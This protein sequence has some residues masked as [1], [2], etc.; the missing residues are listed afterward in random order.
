[1]IGI[2]LEL[3]KQFLLKNEVVAIPTETVYGLAANAL[4]PEAVLKIFEV[5]NRPA[6]DPL[7]VHTD[8]IDK[9][10]TFV[11]E[12][13]E[14]AIQLFKHFSPGALTILLPKKDIIPDITTSGLEKVG[15]RIPNHPLT[16]QLLTQLD[17]PL[18]APSA[19]PFGYVSP[20]TAQHVADQ[21]GEKIPYILD[22]GACS[23]GIEST[24]VSVEPDCIV[25]YRMGGITVEQL[26][27]VSSLPIWVRPHSTSNPQAPGMLESHY[28]PRKKVEIF[29]KSTIYSKQNIGLIAFQ[30]DYGFEHQIILSPSGSLEEAASNLFAALRATEKMP[31]ETVLVE[32]V[33]EVG[34]GRA[35]N[36]RL[37]RAAAK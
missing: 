13:P 23:V 2:N 12:I 16:L 30:Q 20:T 26:Q 5:K 33:E 37:K 1:M 7:I 24:V 28:S 17:F 31:V 34:L 29:S 8:S 19:N 4:Q 6:F 21:L 9:I 35:I 15:V 27:S 11:K 25:V 36:D 18:A 22:G 14:V 3:A 10:N 32:L